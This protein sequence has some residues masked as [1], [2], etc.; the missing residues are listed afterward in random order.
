MFRGPPS[1]YE[2]R[3]FQVV[4]VRKRDSVIRLPVVG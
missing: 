2:E 4:E 3:G 1:P